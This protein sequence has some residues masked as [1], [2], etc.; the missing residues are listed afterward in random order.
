MLERFEWLEVSGADAEAP[1]PRPWA[2]PAV[3]AP[4]PA[5]PAP[6]PMAPDQPGLAL[7]PRIDVVPAGGRWPVEPGGLFL[8]RRQAD[9]LRVSPGLDRLV[10]LEA[11]R[12]QHLP[13]QQAAALRVLGPMRGRA[14]LADEVGLGKTIEAGLVLKELLVRGLVQRALVLAPASLTQQWQEELVTKFDE[15]FEVVREPGDWSGARLIASLDLARSGSHEADALAQAWDLVIVD[16]AHRLRRRTT[17]L[18]RLVSRLNTR[19]LLLLTATPVMNDLDE[20][21]ALVNLLQEGHLGTPRAF[22]S[23][24]A[25]PGNPREPVNEGELRE[26]LASV[27]VRNRRGEVGVQLP[28]RRAGVHHLRMS[29]AEATLYRELTGWIREAL[30]SRPEAGHL[31]LTLGALQ[32]GLTSSPQA[33]AGTLRRLLGSGEVAPAHRRRLAGLAEVAASLPVGRKA[34][35]LSELLARGDTEQLLVYTEFRATQAALAQHL[36]DAG[37]EAVCFHGGLDARERAEVVQAFRA[38]ARVMI[39]TESGAEGLNLQFCHALVNVD[40]PWNPMRVEQRIGRLHRLGQAHPVTVSSLC[41]DGTI[42]AHVLELLATKIRLFELVVGELDVILGE[43]EPR[44]GVEDLVTE[45]WATAS[46][47][48]ELVAAFGALGEALSEAR[49]RYALGKQ[50]GQRLGEVLAAAPGE[51]GRGG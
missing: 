20:L 17:R 7:P 16:E 21:H 50:L 19:H 11:C 9:A 13:H 37:L 48:A 22:L 31:R 4:P 14:L 8:L 12:I 32:R 18:H 39:S 35:A 26:R 45:I 42:E 23:R 2:E 34:L 10:C 38:G 36:Q 44:G 40:L 49:A 41:F 46:D 43:L 51:L 24:Y 25:E 27:M 3:S 33:V 29:E 6:V 15:R 28:P 47:E 30:T 5:P 1:G